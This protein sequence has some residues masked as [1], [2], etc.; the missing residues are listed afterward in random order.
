MYWYWYLSTGTGTWLVEYWL[1]L[2]FTSSFKYL[3]EHASD[4]VQFLV[5]E[6]DIVRLALSVLLGPVFGSRD[7]FSGLAVFL[8]TYANQNGPHNVRSLLVS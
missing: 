1:Q 5:G 2:W 7:Y 6:S 4:S 3:I 8:D